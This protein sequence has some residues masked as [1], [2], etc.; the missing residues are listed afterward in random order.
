[1]ATAADWTDPQ[2]VMTVCT[3]IAGA[4]IPAATE[5]SSGSAGT[6]TKCTPVFAYTVGE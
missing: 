3:P 2:S 6:G 4:T 5:M 1:M